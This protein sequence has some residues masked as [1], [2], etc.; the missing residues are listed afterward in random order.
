MAQYYTGLDVSMEQTDIVTVDDKGKIVF[1]ASIKTN[2]QSIDAAL[3]QAGFPIQK[4]SLESGSWSHWLVKEISALGWNITCI[5]ARSISPL[6]ALKT[7]K[8]DRNDARGI[9]EA[10]RMQSQYIREVYQKSQKSID[11]GALLTT[12]RMLVGQRTA[13]GNTMRG[14]LKTFGLR[15]GIVEPSKFSESL[16]AKIAEQWPETT[17]PSEEY[18]VLALKTLARCFETLRK[19]IKEIDTILNL[20]SKKDDVLKRLMTVPGIGTLTAITYKVVIDNPKRFNKPRLV[21]AY[22][23]MC[24]IQ[25]S[26]GQIKRRGRISKKGPSELRMLLAS[27]GMRILTHCKEPSK[28]RIWGLKISEKHGKKKASMALGRKLA[29]IMHHIWSKN[30]LFVP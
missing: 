4:M 8:T 16:Q 3:K 22:L 2:P 12:R 7:N 18:P 28:L 14:L 20:L 10:V 17:S 23:G 27:S 5:D 29:I 9:A 19:E 26:S 11:L 15:L 13:L 21:G 25:Y 1:E 24:P 30:T 6:L